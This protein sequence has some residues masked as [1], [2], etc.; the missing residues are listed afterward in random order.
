[1]A[2]PTTPPGADHAAEQGQAHIPTELPAVQIPPDNSTLPQQ[3]L[4]H[5]ADQALEHLPTGIPANPTPPTHD[6]TLPQDAIDNVSTVGIV[7]MP[8]W[9]HG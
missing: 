9:L 6:V 1:M 2:R 8:E 3:A 7:H 4:D 5:A